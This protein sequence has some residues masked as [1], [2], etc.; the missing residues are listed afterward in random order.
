MATSS[1]LCQLKGGCMGCCGYDF[2]SKEK[3]NRAIRQNTAEFNSLKNKSKQEL[4]G[5]RDRAHPYDLLH[6]VCR[7]LIEEEG[8]IFCPLHPFRNKG[9][10]L[11]KGH[12]DIDYLCKTAR[13]FAGW[14]EAKQKLFLEFIAE[15]NIDNITH[16]LKIEDN[17]L[18]K[19]F[20][21]FSSRQRRLL[22]PSDK[23]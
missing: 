23:H 16:S 3:I 1:E 18:L 21:E 22:L 8:K 13:E 10:D 6:G 5:F 14:D 15:M 12:C 19:E 20:R 7:N 4:L 11:R 9:D 2:V 17:S